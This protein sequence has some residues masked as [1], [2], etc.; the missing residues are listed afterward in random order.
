MTHSSHLLPGGAWPV[1]L[2]PFT[3]D[4][5]IDWDG[6]DRGSWRPNR[7]AGRRPRAAFAS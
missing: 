4:K 6:L 3:E 7:W 2:T 1:M 5:R